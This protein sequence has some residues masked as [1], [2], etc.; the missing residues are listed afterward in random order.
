MARE[1][2]ITDQFDEWW[3]TLTESEQE[4]IRAAV[5]VLE[6]RGPGLRDRT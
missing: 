5:E 4:R 2:E 3:Q 1:I 6:E